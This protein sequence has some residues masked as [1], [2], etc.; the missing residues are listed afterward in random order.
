MTLHLAWIPFVEP[1]PSMGSWWPLLLVPLAFGI[2]MI[3]KALRVT[4]LEHY[5]SS[6]M[7]M[8]SQIVG[9]MILLAIGL[10]LVVQF[11]IPMI[12]AS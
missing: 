7:I 6:V 2:S 4:T 10:Y 9:S 11:L 3:Y 1:L 8:T 5:V 12:P